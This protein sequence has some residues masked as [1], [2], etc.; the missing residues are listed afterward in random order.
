MGEGVEGDEKKNYTLGGRFFF[1]KIRIVKPM[2]DSVAD[3]HKINIAVVKPAISS[4]SIPVSINNIAIPI[5]KSSRLS[6]NKILFL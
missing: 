5:K 3:R 2:A 6:S 4:R 1:C